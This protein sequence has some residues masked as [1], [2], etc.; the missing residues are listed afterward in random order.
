MST[1]AVR[2]SHATMLLMPLRGFVRAAAAIVMML[3]VFD[4][5]Q[6]LAYQAKQR[7]PFIDW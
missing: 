1:L 6:H 2:A 5:A 3:E 7:H 4:E